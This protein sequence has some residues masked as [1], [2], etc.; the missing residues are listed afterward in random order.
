MAIEA[1]VLFLSRAASIIAVVIF[2][3]W[4]RFRYWSHNYLFEFD[5]RDGYE[6]ETAKEPLIGPLAACAVCTLCL[7]FI[8]VESDSMV[9]PVLRLSPA[10]QSSIAIYLIPTIVRL[11]KHWEV[12][13]AVLDKNR[14]VEDVVLNLTIGFS[15]NVSIY[16]SPILVLL[17]WKLGHPLSLA[18]GLFETILYGLCGWFPPLILGKGLSTFLDGVVLLVV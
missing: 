1:A 10:T 17:A 2:L 3:L 5:S 16:L 15:V 7:A 4:L 13:G 11:G 12:V 8:A 9:L 18:Y 14:D 6:A